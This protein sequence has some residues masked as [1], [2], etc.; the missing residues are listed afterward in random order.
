MGVYAVTSLASC[1]LRF[2][3]PEEIVF[4]DPARTPLYRELADALVRDD[5]AN[6]AG[7][8]MFDSNY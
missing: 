4:L 2:R 7:H 8:R 6:S 1:L 3:C 5:G